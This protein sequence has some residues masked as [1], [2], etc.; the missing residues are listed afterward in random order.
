VTQFSSGKVR[1]I[2]TL[3]AWV[4]FDVI[5]SFAMDGIEPTDDDLCR[6]PLTNPANPI[7]TDTRIYRAERMD[8]TSPK[9]WAHVLRKFESADGAGVWLDAGCTHEEITHA[10]KVLTRLAALS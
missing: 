8:M 2:E 5:A 7:L 1:H 4:R 6:H 10:R 9:G 3:S